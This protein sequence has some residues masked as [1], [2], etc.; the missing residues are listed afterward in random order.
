MQ[1]NEVQR[2]RLLVLSVIGG[3]IIL[4]IVLALIY[5][6]V[7]KNPYGDY[8][9]IQNYNEN[10]KNIS[11][12]YEHNISSQLYRT[13]KDNGDNENLT[14]SDVKD[15]YIRKDSAEQE[16]VK[17]NSQYSGS[18]IVDI[19]SLRQSYLVQY[20]Y[21]RNPDD[22][23]TSGYPILISCV[24]KEDVIYEDFECG[25]STIEAASTMDPIITI[26]PHSTLSYEAKAVYQDDTL[27]IY[28]DLDIP[29]SDLKG[30]QQSDAQVVALYKKEFT[31]YVRSQGFTPENYTISYNYND[32]G[33]KVDNTIH[34]GD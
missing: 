26:L 19:E 6:Q 23:F 21:S 25:D 33:E 12:D 9:V 8:I 4:G 11:R 17:R 27:V 14:G 18:F 34:I 2:K 16:E 24:N 31:D 10:V 30:N 3:V 13:V 22:G 20:N 28:V 7:T 15:A 5:Q 1:S 32:A 29:S